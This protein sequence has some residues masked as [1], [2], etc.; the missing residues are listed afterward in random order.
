VLDTTAMTPTIGSEVAIDREAMLSGAHAE[1]LRDLLVQ[2]GV[3][4]IRDAHLDDAELRAFSETLGELRQ[5]T[6][7]E[8]EH[9]GMLKVVHIPGSYF[10]HVDGTYTGTPPFATVISPQVV[11]PEGGTTEFAN[12][13]A[14][15]EGLS[16]QDQEELLS[17]RVVHTMKAAGN[18]AVPEPSL[19]QFQGW[20]GYRCVHPLV[21][22]HASGRRSLVL[23]ATA[24]HVEDMHFV[25]SYELL[26]RLLAHATQ[27]DYVYRHQWREGD[28]VL[29]DNTGTMHRVR[30]FDLDSGRLMHRFTL[31]GVEAFTG[32]AA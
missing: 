16:E 8:Q 29:W 23:G 12:T 18:N 22:Q 21:W 19:E 3:L 24:S 7:Y 15:Y 14:A 31:E 11:A 1:E 32:A 17:A 6:P 4:V 28:V 5:G 20:M 13:Y 9:K 26:Q 30:P 27:D 10:W 2:R 25:Y